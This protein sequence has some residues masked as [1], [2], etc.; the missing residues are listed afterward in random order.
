MHELGIMNEIL[1]TA[2]G[3][4]EKNNGKK[5]TKITLRAG[6][7]SG[8]VPRIC[9][10]MFGV[11]A[12]GTPAERCEVVIEEVPAV[13]KCID[14]GAETSYDEPTGGYKCHACGSETL[15]LVSGYKFQLIN[16]A[17]I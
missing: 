17:I 4:A 15:R 11:I 8:V 5:V 10:S 3:V 9:S 14:C 2:L 6:A 12:E 7:M 1:K 16:V 13:F